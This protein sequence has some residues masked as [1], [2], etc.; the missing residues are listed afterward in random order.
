VGVHQRDWVDY[1]GRT[2][3]SCNV[4]M[5]LATKASSFVMA[6]GVRSKPTNLALE[7]HIEH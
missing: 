6:Y 3:F 2:E 1:V 7:G 5:Y 4:A